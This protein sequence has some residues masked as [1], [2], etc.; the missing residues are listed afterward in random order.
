MTKTMTDE[1]KTMTEKQLR[2]FDCPWPKT[3]EEL[4][5]II[6]A[7][8]ERE[9]EYGTCVYAMSIAATAAFYYMSRRLGV[10]GFQAMLADM[11]F[12]RRVRHMKGPF[13]ILDAADLVYPQYDMIGKVQEWIREWMP[14]AAKE[15]VKRLNEHREEAVHPEV[16]AHWKRL[17]GGVQP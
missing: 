6:S 5:A 1:L 12:I 16:L 10:T 7:L 13:G 2:D 15:A 3:L 11:D 8:A 4:N 9:H 17:A 14:W